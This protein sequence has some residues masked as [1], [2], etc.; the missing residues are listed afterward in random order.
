MADSRI[1]VLHVITR[2]IQGGARQIVC[3]LLEG[4]PFE[5]ALVC[6][7]EGFVDGVGVPVF[8]VPD[9]VRE[10]APV[11]DLRA[12]AAIFGII[13]KWRPTV[14]H[15]H[16]YKSG[17]VGSFAARAAGVRGIVFTPHGHIFQPEARIPGVPPGGPKL[18]ILRWV[19]R[20]AQM[21]AHRITALSAEDL[22]QQIRLRLSPRS[23][24]RIVRNGIDAD[25]FRLAPA[26]RE[27]WGLN[28]FRPLLGTV[29]RLTSEKGH[30]VL[31]DA[32]PLVRRVMP[33]AGLAIVGGG[34]REAELRARAGDGVRLLGPLESRNILP[35][36]DLYVH[37]SHYESQGLAILEAMAAGKPVVATDAGGVRDVVRHGETG[38]LVPPGNPPALAQAVLRLASDPGEAA[39]LA[40]NAA[41]RVRREYSL[42]A[43]LERYASLYRSLLA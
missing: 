17:V 3:R 31:L 6:G 8:V 24:Y 38:L 40:A 21:C 42:D 33:S 11:R 29:G 37:P 43:M 16:T 28:G 30:E 25:A 19:T 4:L 9:L 2:M 10:P 13:R 36:F 32:M 5:Q 41:E 20:A 26:A 12:T 35:S 34:E 1:R 27:R 22:E 14:V 39:R 7:P 18:E 15:S 23:K